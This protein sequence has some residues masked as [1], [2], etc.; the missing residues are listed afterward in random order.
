MEIFEA[1]INSCLLEYIGRK[2]G[3]TILP[4]RLTLQIPGSLCRIARNRIIPIIGFSSAVDVCEDWLAKHLQSGVVLSDPLL[5]SP[6]NE[7]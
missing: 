7:D 3:R 1:Q 6:L 2:R 4:P 5:L